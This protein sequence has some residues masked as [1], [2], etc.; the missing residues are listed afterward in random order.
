MQENIAICSLLRTAIVTPSWI[1]KYIQYSQQSKGWV[2]TTHPWHLG[3]F[4][5]NFFVAWDTSTTSATK[6]V[7]TNILQLLKN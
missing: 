4:R 6:C 7:P 5:C 2:D 3:Y 1:S